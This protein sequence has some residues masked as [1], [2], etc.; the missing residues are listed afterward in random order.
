MKTN[1]KRKTLIAFSIIVAITMLIG[2]I[3][4][5]KAPIIITEMEPQHNISEKIMPVFS[6]TSDSIL[7]FIPY[8]VTV[9]N[10]RFREISLP[11]IYYKTN[12]D[13]YGLA[14]S[15]NG[16]SLYFD[17]DGK[18]LNEDLMITKSEKI[19]Y[20]EMSL[21]MKW[22]KWKEANR[23]IIFPF[24][25][26]S[27]YFYK[28]TMLKYKT[29]RKTFVYLNDNFREKQTQSITETPFVRIPK[30]KIDSLYQADKKTKI[31][32]ILR[33]NKIQGWFQIHYQM[34]DG[35][36]KFYDM[37]D[38]IRKMSREE[39]FLLMSSSPLNNL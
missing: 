21:A 8:K 33:T 27:F 14:S 38:S 22:E 31:A 7:V 19:N 15:T 26:K 24:C 13:D 17:E 16:N 39:L 12:H 20:N 1:L 36:Q 25:S 6:K 9:S 2:I 29:D 4:Y 23:N 35:T 34:K 5:T 10:N 32:L 28:S 11:D 37:Y 3:F 30:D 18:Q